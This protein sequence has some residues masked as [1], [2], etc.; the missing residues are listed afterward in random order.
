MADDKEKIEWIGGYP[1]VE[2]VNT[3]PQEPT[4]EQKLIEDIIWDATTPLKGW[5]K[6][7]AFI[8]RVLGN[9]NR[10]G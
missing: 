10:T 2:G 8:N 3:P 7:Q 4:L 1:H 9:D 5:A 6:V